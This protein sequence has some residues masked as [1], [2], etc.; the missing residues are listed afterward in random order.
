MWNEYA[1]YLL[2]EEV[3]AY[4]IKDTAGEISFHP[5]WMVILGLDQQILKRAMRLVNTGGA[6]LADALEP[7]TLNGL[8]SS[9]A[10]GSPLLS[11]M[12]HAVS[13]VTR[14]LMKPVAPSGGTG[15]VPPEAAAL[16]TSR[17][18]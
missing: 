17:A 11:Q 9:G 12:L 6:M 7:P 10:I 13:S 18:G 2:G 16:L 14:S 1:D 8:S 4:T 15:E 3:Y 5:S